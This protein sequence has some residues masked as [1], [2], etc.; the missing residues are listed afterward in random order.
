MIKE[1]NIIILE[2]LDFISKSLALWE[3]LRNQSILITG[4]SGLLGSY[5]VKSLLYANNVFDL[6]LKVIGTYRNIDSVNERLIEYLDEPNFKLVLHDIAEP[7]PNDLPYAD[8]II[9]AASQASPKYY[10]IDPVG[11]ILANSTGTANLLNYAVK[12]KSKRFLFFSSGE[13]YGNPID[14]NELIKEDDYGYIDPMNIR[15]CYAES[16]RIGE[17]MCVSWGKQYGVHVNVVRPFHTYGPGIALNDG[18]VFADFV[19]NAVEGKDI[20]LKSNGLTKRSF[21]YIS[22]A[23][24]GFLIVLLS[25]KDAEAYNIGNPETEISMKDLALKIV[26]LRPDL[27]LSV[28]FD[29]KN[30]GDK[31]MRSQ[32]L[33]AYP[34]IDKVSKIGWKP[35]IGLR[36]GFSRTIKSFLV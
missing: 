16:K 21:C 36:E 3:D 25:G 12:N 24:I 2:D 34:S 19:A 29:V 27:D 4:C 33:R 10:G 5:L 9:H 35:S 11:T 18:R 15:S 31:Y 20:I 28:K 23:T 17:T 6:N 13:V 14:P 32:V 7:I 22:D 26:D 8:F 30:Q 1:N